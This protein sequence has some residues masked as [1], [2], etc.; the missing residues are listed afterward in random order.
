M[1]EY[2][3]QK[4]E[5]RRFEDKIMPFLLSNE[6]PDHKDT[7]TGINSP[8]LKEKR[9]TSNFLVLVVDDMADQRQITS[10]MLRHLGFSV[11]TVSNGEDA[12]DFIRNN[13]VDVVVLDMVMDPGMDGLDTYKE[14]IKIRP[15]QK[16]II[17]TGHPDSLRVKTA[18]SL[19]AGLCMRKPLT[20]DGLKQ[21]FKEQ[22]DR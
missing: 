5:A 12:V 1:L 19:G 16:T 22:L 6:I 14:I 9:T 3:N 21:L 2:L 8:D 10:M 4:A 7:A 13:P 11:A 18:Q 17:A 15:D 20:I